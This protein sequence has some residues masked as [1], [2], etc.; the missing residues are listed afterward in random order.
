MRSRP[1]LRNTTLALVT[2]MVTVA[3][4]ET[5]KPELFPGLPDDLEAVVWA[6]SPLL[7]N[8]TNIDVDA[9]G[10][11]WVTE[12]V[13]YRNFNNDS[14]VFPH[15]PKG[16]RVLILEDT[17]RDGV[18]D[19]STVFVQDEDLISPLG[20]A[21]IGN[22]V[23]VSCSPNLIV[24]T[25]DNGDDVPDRKEILLT[26]FGGYDHDHSLHSLVGGPDGNLYF[27]T[28]NAGPHQVT[29][30]S[31]WTLRSG[32]IY[33]GGSPYNM[34]N[35]G[36]LKSDDGKVW[37]GGLTLKI[38][39][40][41][42][43]MKVMAHNFRNSYEVFVDS[44]GDMWQNDNDDEVL[45]CRTS[46]IMEGGNAGYFSADGTRYWRA[47]HRPWQ[48]VFT[49]HWHQEDPGVIPAG[50]RTG[51]GA[52]TGIV[53]IEDDALGE[54]Y[55]GMLLS[56]DA[57]RNTVFAYHPSR[58]GSGFALRNR[59]NLITSLTADNPR[60]VWNDSANHVD[61]RKWFRPSDV[62]IGT[63]GSLF[64][65]D[66]YDP[67][68][69][70]HQMRDTIAYGRIY[71][72]TPKRKKLKTPDLDFNTTE[73]LIEAIKNPAVNV[74]FE[75]SRL[76]ESKGDAVVDDLRKLLEDKN[77]FIRYRAIWLLARLGSKGRNEIT[78]LLS[79]EDD[80]TRVVALRALRRAG[81]LIPMT[82]DP[83]PV[84]RREVSIALAEHNYIRKVDILSELALSCPTDDPWYA[85]AI[86]SAAGGYE[87]ELYAAITEGRDALSW[88]SNIAR[89]LWTI[90]PSPAVHDFELRATKSRDVRDR[91][92]AVTALAFIPHASAAR[93]MLRLTRDSVEDVREQALYW[94]SFRRGN[95]WY[96]LLDWN[97]TPLDAEYQNT[98]AA[99]KVRMSMALN[100]EL[101][102]YERSRNA[103]QLA[104]NPIGGRLLLTRLADNT[105]P[106]W[107]LP[108][109]A[110]AVASNPDPGVRY[111][112]LRMLNKPSGQAITVSH[113]LEL[114]GDAAIGKALFEK[115]CAAC[116][117]VNN[118]GGSAGPDLSN[119]ATKYDRASMLD[120]IVDP[121]AGVAFGYEAWNI[122]MNDGST[123]V[124]FI[125]ADNKNTL[126][127]RDL[128]GSLH[129]LS[130][131]EVV[132]RTK[133]E[134]SLMPAPD[135]LGMSAEDVAHVATYLL[136]LTSQ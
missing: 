46:W 112:V 32:S 67:V 135:E 10:R 134:G 21:V 4:R 77:P 110:K 130:E 50:D 105:F 51:A 90:H 115:T 49:A 42:E 131:G 72:I 84:V 5:D 16:D 58:E 48:D 39:P 59:V 29:D 36:N 20:I 63:D 74:R 121:N 35:Q 1:L 28:G 88:P 3:C 65:A 100:G 60:Y 38:N 43:H 94:A 95:D 86:A 37:V 27:T 116:H 99:M 124:G 119:I 113:V 57:G 70:G 12:A 78:R 24:F 107:L 104:A 40:A 123:L 75:A 87:N 92:D 22:K 83:S 118:K 125:V 47:D 15:H 85:C 34:E 68:V 122:V 55:R 103:A 117:A 9:R 102:E 30:K 106:R 91:L 82:N 31:G 14:T 129:T 11:L 133:Q 41:G 81:M 101:S 18:A 8:P 23:Y 98:L 33:T 79:H 89:V 126:I 7:Y 54:N 52:P 76:L 111:Q 64:I 25:D 62:A 97:Q 17:D 93:A 73:G 109:I 96:A 128:S 44:R 66:W 6:E 19:K 132:S 13:N 120:A 108:T 114:N 71:R 127:M 56:A 53:L 26:G 80:E 61:P 2:L 45:A 136:S 69:G